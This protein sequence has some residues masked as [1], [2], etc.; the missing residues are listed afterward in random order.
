M[1]IRPQDVVEF[2]EIYK[3]RFGT[4]PSRELARIMLLDLVRQMHA[5]YKPIS[6]QQ[7]ANVMNKNEY[8]ANKNEQIR[9]ASNC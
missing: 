7:L 4:T 2:Q 6:S 9:T 8:E 1:I 5:I 3:A